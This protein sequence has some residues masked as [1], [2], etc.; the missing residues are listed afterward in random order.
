MSNKAPK[1]GTRGVFTHP[2]L[3]KMGTMTGHV[4]FDPFCG[5]TLFMPDEKYHT[6]LDNLYGIEGEAGLFFEEGTFAT[7]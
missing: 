4:E 3:R 7:I 2:H 6:R 1:D 5:E